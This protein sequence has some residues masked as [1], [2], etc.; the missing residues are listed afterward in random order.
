MDDLQTSDG[1]LEVAPEKLHHHRVSG[2]QTRRWLSTSTFVDA[3]E[4]TSYSTTTLEN[5][6]N[7]T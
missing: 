1:D 5:I 3:E 2:Y 7:E 4:T 6:S